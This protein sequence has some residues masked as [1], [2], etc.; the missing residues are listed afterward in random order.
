MCLNHPKTMTPAQGVEKLS[1]TKLGPDAKRK[2]SIC[3]K[4]Q[5]PLPS[6]C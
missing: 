3:S 6:T 2:L 5:G 4:A 1:S